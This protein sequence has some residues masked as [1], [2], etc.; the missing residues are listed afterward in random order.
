MGVGAGRFDADRSA[1]FGA[2][3]QRRAGFETG[4]AARLRGFETGEASRLRA[5]ETLQGFAPLAQSL[6]EQAAS[7]LLTAG[8]AQRQLDQRALDLAYGDYLEQRQYP[9][10]QLNFALGALQGV[11]YNTR[12]IGLEQ[13][14][15][16]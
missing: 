14:Q 10:E 6:T 16:L 7:G 5:A 9:Q 1:R 2:E 12:T 8:Q 11:P 3:D 4:E 13:H 15:T